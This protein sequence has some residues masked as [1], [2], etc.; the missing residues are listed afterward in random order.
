[1]NAEIPL[2]YPHHALFHFGKP[3]QYLGIMT[4]NDQA[5]FDQGLHFS[6]VSDISIFIKSDGHGD[7]MIKVVIKPTV[8]RRYQNLVCGSIDHHVLRFI[9]ML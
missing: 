8:I 3:L 1:M 2:P 7:H 6:Q 5:G 9:S 4:R